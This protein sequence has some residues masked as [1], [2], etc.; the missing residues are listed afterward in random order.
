MIEIEKLAKMMGNKIATQL[1]LND[2]RRAV[3]TYG[4]IGILQ[5]IV[6]FALIIF[7]GLLLD[8]TYE[9]FIIFF[10][11]SAIRKSSGG[12]H[13]R[14]ML[15]C[16]IMSI[17]AI[18]ILSVLSRYIF[19]SPISIYINLLITVIVY[20]ICLLIFYYRVPLGSPN[21][22]INRP[23]K[24]KRL[25]K[26][27]FINLMILFILSI[28]FIIL[29]DFNTKFYSL[30]ISVRLAMLWQFFTI[31]KMGVLFVEKFDSIINKLFDNK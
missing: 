15:G 3:I 26:L 12:A 17:V 18:V 27:S 13:A 8:I 7:I 29:A 5:T 28:V 19:A 16:N 10:S 31:T 22:P 21:K 25:R 2:D 20:A 11:V 23:E 30:A 9:S 24:I 6:L 4:L 14:T 1:D